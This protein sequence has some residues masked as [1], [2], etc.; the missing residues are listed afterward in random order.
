MRNILIAAAVLLGVALAGGATANS[1]ADSGELVLE[2]RL[3]AQIHPSDL[4]AWMKPLTAEPNHVGSPHDKQ[5]A[6]QI[7]AWFKSWGWNAH[8][9]TFWVL[10]PTPKSETLEM[11]APIPFKATLQ[12]PPIPGDTS[13]TATQPALHAYAVYQGDGDVTAEL[14]YVNYGMPQDY[15]RLQRM[16]IS[17]KGKIAIARYGEGWRGLKPK[18][19]QDHGALGC[20]IYSDP[21]QDGYAD[22]RTYPAGPMRPARGIQ[23]GSVSDMALYPGDPLTPGIGATRN[24]KRLQISQ[25]TT[26]LKI[27]TL[28]ISYADAQVLL[29]QLGGPPAPANWRGALGITYHV[30][31]GPA[32]I[33]LAVKS[34]WSLKP[35]Y[36]VIAVMPG[37]Y[38]PNQWVIRGNHHDAWVFGAS[39]PMSGQVALLAE[40]Q[41]IGALVKQGWRPKRTIVYASW[42]GE[43][44]MLLGSTEWGETHAA[45][46]RQKAVLYI[47][48]DTN[49]RGFLMAEGS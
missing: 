29:S 24:A 20:I 4:R 25:A 19:A 48:S 26:I 31:P 12:E 46:L 37:A 30:G 2:H 5:N 18:L 34:D 33:H 35:I 38:Y 22:A 27:P 15:E 7:L 6:Q 23:R 47:N 41:A 40:A 21:Q 44:P 11:V 42:D 14:V 45:E 10:Y 49:A 1:S 3:D 28:P 17:V 36:D 8:I 32:K 43:E 39:D 9:E 13:A 16:G